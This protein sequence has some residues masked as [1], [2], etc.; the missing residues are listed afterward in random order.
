MCPNIP[1]IRLG[2]G[3]I[4]VSVV[5]TQPAILAHVRER[6]RHF[7]VDHAADFTIEMRYFQDPDSAARFLDVSA[8]LVVELIRDTGTF[9]PRAAIAPGADTCSSWSRSN[10]A[11]VRKTK[12]DSKPEVS[13]VGRRVVFR[14]VDFVG[15]MDLSAGN[16]QVVFAKDMQI[17]AVESFLRIAYSFLAVEHGGILLHSAAVVRGPNGY[18]FP[19]PSET[20]K[21]TI[22]S[23]ATLHEKVLS[24]EMVLVRKM[25]GVY[26]VYSSPFFGT[27]ES[28]ELNF[29]APL[30]A[31]LLPI[32]DTQVYLEKTPSARALAK[33]LA[34]VLF[35]DQDPAA[36]ERLMSVATDILVAVPF[37]NLHFRRDGT[38]W[39]CI[40]ELEQKEFK[41][42]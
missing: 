15:S 41:P 23:L 39:S 40:E 7:V 10:C 1:Y 8:G 25:N 5:S 38:F 16:G 26:R 6:Y 2:I 21:S 35:F 31:A 37:F 12:L 3:E 14:R 28:A 17:I 20:G 34:S 24:D 18:I 4:C 19:G 27:N 29:G 22:A 11:S 42:C 36:N 9:A 13:R 33:L 32:K 30:R